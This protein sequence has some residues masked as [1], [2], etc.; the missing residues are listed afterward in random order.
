MKAGIYRTMA[1]TLLL[2]GAVQLQGVTGRVLAAGSGMKTVT[3]HIR[4]S[5]GKYG[6][7]PIKLTVAAGTKVVW[8][9]NSD[10]PHTVTGTHGWKW[11]SN[12]FSQNH[13]V[14]TVFN[15]AGTYRY[16]CAIHPYM[17]ATVVVKK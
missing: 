5:S 11:A 15:K 12:T 10:A 7:H 17:T 3:V 13:S 14:S 16:M 6:F 9:N 4:E 1:A 2:A 8:T